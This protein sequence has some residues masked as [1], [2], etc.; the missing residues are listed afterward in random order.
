MIHHPARVNLIRQKAAA[1]LKTIPDLEA[2]VK[3]PGMRERLQ[4]A[5]FTVSDVERF[6]LGQLEREQRTA[7]QEARWLNY[8]TMALVLA[9]LEL[10]PIQDAVAKYGDGVVSVP[11]K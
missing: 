7:E 1:Y 11:Q 4:H 5:R 9:E 2:R 6:F 10:N 8:T 3:D